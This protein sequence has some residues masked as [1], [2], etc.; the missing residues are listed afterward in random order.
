VYYGYV[1]EMVLKYPNISWQ[2]SYTFWPEATALLAHRDYSQPEACN[3]LC[4]Q[5]L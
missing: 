1:E 3:T 5:R 2:A 4:G